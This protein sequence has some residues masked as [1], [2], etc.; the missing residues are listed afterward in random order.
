M[1]ALK[2]AIRQALLDFQETQGR[3][4]AAVTQKFDPIQNMEKIYRV[5][6]DALVEKSWK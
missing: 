2:M 6:A 4:H 3:S 1:E 5:Y